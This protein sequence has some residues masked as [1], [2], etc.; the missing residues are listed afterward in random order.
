[1]AAPLRRPGDARHDILHAWHWDTITQG[2][3]PGG[4]RGAGQVC[5][6]IREPLKPLTLQWSE[7]PDQ[8]NRQCITAWLADQIGGILP[9]TGTLGGG[10]IVLSEFVHPLAAK[11]GVPVR[12]GQGI[13]HIILDANA[14]AAIAGLP[15]NGIAADTH[16]WLRL[17]GQRQ[18]VAAG[19][20]PGG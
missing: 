12:T 8:E 4:V 10:G 1:M 17:E 7:T 3:V 11:N 5:P 14:V 2:L 19:T 6:P 20:S 13:G 9:L 15:V 16:G 18:V